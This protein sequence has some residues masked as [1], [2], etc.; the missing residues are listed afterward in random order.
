MLPAPTSVTHKGLCCLPR[1]WGRNFAG[2]FGA[3]WKLWSSLWLCW[4]V[5]GVMVEFPHLGVGDARPEAVLGILR[6]NE[7]C[8]NDY[9]LTIDCECWYGITWR[10]A[11]DDG[12]MVALVKRHGEEQV[13]Q[14]G[15]SDPEHSVIFVLILGQ[16][17]AS[18][19]E[20]PKG[21]SKK[22]KL[23]KC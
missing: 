18:D 17:E 6:K 12:A 19:P 5:G 11:R 22:V 13:K 16:V 9:R 21:F 1:T 8:D 20:T 23:W 10:K 15:V 14:V 2:I 3:G 7:N 4:G